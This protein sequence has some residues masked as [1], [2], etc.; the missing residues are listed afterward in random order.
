MRQGH[1][2]TPLRSTVCTARRSLRITQAHSLSSLCICTEHAVAR[3]LR[4]LV[5]MRARLVPALLL[6]VEQGKTD[7]VKAK[8]AL[9]L[10]LHG[11]ADA[12]VLGHALERR[13]LVQLTRQEVYKNRVVMDMECE[14]VFDEA[15]CKDDSERNTKLVTAV[16]KNH[17]KV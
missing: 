15:K 3:T 2:R 8:A 4:A 7:A 5:P 14:P 12:A 9:A 11:R 17:H 6:A 13:L 10:A 1:R 16:H